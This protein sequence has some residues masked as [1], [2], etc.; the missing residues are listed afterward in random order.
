MSRAKEQ[1]FN[2][3]WRE[4]FVAGILLTIAGCNASGRPAGAPPRPAAPAP[5]AAPAMTA[6]VSSQIYKIIPGDTVYGVAQRFNVPVRTLIEGNGLQPPYRLAP[7]RQ[8]R[9]PASERHVVQP[10]ETLL[11][12]SRIYGA[13]QSSLARVNNLSAPYN[14]TAGQS[15]LLPGRVE[16]QRLALGD[17]SGTTSSSTPAAGAGSIAVEALPAPGVPS[18]TGSAAPAAGSTGQVDVQ[19]PVAPLAAASNDAAVA[20]ST[21]PEP[22]PPQPQPATTQEAAVPPTVPEP[23]PRTSGQFLWPVDGKVISEFGSKNG[24]L[25]NDGINI[26]ASRG[27]TVR[28]AENGVVAYAGNELRGFGNLLLIR[29]ADG[30]VTAYAHNEKLL[31]KRGDKVSRGQ[32]I[33]EVGSSGNVSSAQLHF[34]LRRGAEPVDPMKYLGS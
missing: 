11:G 32:P 17:A 10:G 15:L 30:W 3:S 23:S 7:G 19:P 27:T 13:D 18:G 2:G 4:L 26:E 16:A 24:G 6:D 25:H 28:A 14:L 29:H 21:A 9:V 34:E 1:P 20:P 33:A 22:A 12:I 8:L 5:T 31:V